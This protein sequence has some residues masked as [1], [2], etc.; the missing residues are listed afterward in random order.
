MG[1]KNQHSCHFSQTG[2]CFFFYVS[3]MRLKLWAPELASNAKPTSLGDLDTYPF[4]APIFSF[5]FL[6]GRFFHEDGI[7]KSKLLRRCQAHS[8]CYN[9]YHEVTASFLFCSYSS[10][11]FSLTMILIPQFVV[12]YKCWHLH[13]PCPIPGPI[14]ALPWFC[15]KIWMKEAQALWGFR[16]DCLLLFVTAVAQWD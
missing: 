4:C 3:S 15:L 13:Y 6:S 8:M 7:N 14:P 9:H 12:H 10:S 11:P 2:C 5:V 16:K 1:W